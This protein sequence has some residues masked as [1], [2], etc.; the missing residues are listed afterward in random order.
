L[1]DV[2]V[3]AEMDH[4]GGV[5]VVAAPEDGAVFEVAAVAVAPST[6]GVEL[7]EEGGLVG[8]VE[9]GVVTRRLNALDRLYAFVQIDESP[10]SP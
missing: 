2:E 5:V 8:G 6:V 10:F 9:Q 7:I 4:F 3:D 1:G